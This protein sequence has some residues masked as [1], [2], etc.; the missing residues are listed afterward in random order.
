MATINLPDKSF[1]ITN[2]T[3][4]TANTPQ[5]VLAIGQ[6][7][8][9]GSAKVSQLIE[10]IGNNGEELAL[11]G[12]GSILASAIY[13][14]KKLNTNVQIDAITVN[15]AIEGVAATGRIIFS[16]SVTQTSTL[17]ISIQSRLN[18]KFTLTFQSGTSKQE[19]AEE[20]IKKINSAAYILVTASNPSEGEVFLTANNKGTLGNKIGL[21]ISELPQGLY[22]TSFGQPGSITTGQNDP[23]I[24]D[25]LNLIDQSRYQTIMWPFPEQ[26]ASITDFLEN[27]FN[28][29]DL[30]LDGVGVIVETNLFD[31]LLTRANNIVARSIVLIG[32][33]TSSAFLSNIPSIFEFD[34]NIN[35]QFCAIRSLRL[36]LGANISQYLTGA[37]NPTAFGGPVMA[38]IPYHNT[39]FEN[40]PVI[41]NNAGWTREEQRT[42]NEGGVSFLGNDTDRS[43]IISGEMVTTAAVS[44]NENVKSTFKYLN[45]VDTAS[46]IR[47]HFYLINE[48]DFAQASLTLGDRIVGTSLVNPAYIALQQSDIYDDLSGTDENGI[49][50]Q[51]TVAGT[52]AQEYFKE[53][54]TLSVDIKTGTVTISALV[55]IVTQLRELNGIVQIVFDLTNIG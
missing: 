49:L 26:Y 46:N 20:L 9:T 54:L 35:A 32:I 14:F 42:L 34:F 29:N 4:D 55:P 36:T 40:L 11:F 31:N 22:T 48:F 5:K 15:D 28:V 50:W 33:K 25:L 10:N 13:E 19:V 24:S 21:E 18:Y 7:L 44:N 2:Q 51:L 39:P 52:E 27:R 53:N 12:D 30:I 6:K 37:G 38:S 17:V 43:R 3:F 41:L 45:Y 16:G 47:E 1:Q 23:D 8:S